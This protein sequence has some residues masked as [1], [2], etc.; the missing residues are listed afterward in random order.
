MGALF[1][2]VFKG[3]VKPLALTVGEKRKD[4]AKEHGKLQK[5][6]AQASAVGGALMGGQYDQ[7]SSPMTQNIKGAL[8]S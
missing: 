2:E 6:A 4:V 7:S 5:K 1:N 3:N 8:F